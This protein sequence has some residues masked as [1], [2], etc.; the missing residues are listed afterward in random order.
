M[1]GKEDKTRRL[2]RELDAIEKKS[3]AMRRETERLRKMK[4]DAKHALAGRYP[5]LFG[6]KAN[7]DTMSTM[8]VATQSDDS[9]GLD[10]I[11]PN[12]PEMSKDLQEVYET[13]V[14]F[15]KRDSSTALQS[16]SLPQ[17]QNKTIKQQDSLE[18]S[19]R[20]SDIL[21]A[22]GIK[23]TDD[24]SIKVKKPEEKKIAA[25]NGGEFFIPVDYETY[26]KWMAER[27]N[28][29]LPSPI[30]PPV[31]ERPIVQN[32]A[33]NLSVA[34]Q[35]A[36]DD[37]SQDA[38]DLNSQESKDEKSKSEKSKSEKSEKLVKKEP[39]PV[40]AFVHVIGH[41][42]E[43]NSPKSASLKK[44]N[45]VIV[46]KPLEQ[47]HSEDLK[48]VERDENFV[49]E[50]DANNDDKLYSSESE[51]LPKKKPNVLPVKKSAVL[52]SSSSSSNSPLKPKKE[53]SIPKI[54]TL[55]LQSESE[56]SE[57]APQAARRD[58]DVSGPE[59]DVADDFWN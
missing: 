32:N 21:A 51:S 30:N 1:D 43:Q 42:D 23:T 36:D 26:A 4:N 58:E 20:L 41:P 34:E 39:A 55:Q 48:I 17:F 52:S 33:N 16:F 15:Q 53:P 49:I 46:D 44:D 19:D 57:P 25:K 27:Q 28:Q 45:L 3:E 18:D 8:S 14:N 56:S 37:T 31:I 54:K 38:A 59:M 5:D 9:L 6:N 2:L 47:S 7:F 22:Y 12:R 24:D 35:E 10:D 40:D 11:V 50:S 13:L 29:K